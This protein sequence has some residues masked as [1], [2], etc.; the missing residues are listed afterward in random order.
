MFYGSS[1][2]KIK[3]IIYQETKL[4]GVIPYKK[5]FYSK[6][7]KKN[8]KSHI[9]DYFTNI[10][11]Y[12]IFATPKSLKMISIDETRY[13]LYALLEVGH[14][15]EKSEIVVYDLGSSNITF[16]KLFSINEIDIKDR[17]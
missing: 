3:E 1:S 10:T 6:E 17:Y 14:L 5:G 16:K 15:N 7:C 4:L 11:N 12:S 9:F 13:F 2:G 8:L